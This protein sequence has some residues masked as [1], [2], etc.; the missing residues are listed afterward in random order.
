MGMALTRGCR[1]LGSGARGG[2]RGRRRRRGGSPARWSPATAS[3]AW[4]SFGEDWWSEAAAMA[5]RRR[6]GGAG[7]P[8]DDGAASGPGVG[9]GGKGIG[10]RCVGAP[11]IQIARGERRVGIVGKGVRVSVPPGRG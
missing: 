7:Q 11:P 5:F 8:G 3:S 2:R 4:R 6:S 9:L 1:G 10:A